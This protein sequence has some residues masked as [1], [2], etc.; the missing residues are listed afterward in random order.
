MC[1]SRA[2]RRLSPFALLGSVQQSCSTCGRLMSICGKFPTAKKICASNMMSY[3]RASLLV[4]TRSVCAE[5][6][7][8]RLDKDCANKARMKLLFPSPNRIHRQNSLFDFSTCARTHAQQHAARLA[9]ACGI[10]QTKTI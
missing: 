8:A 6:K 5:T 2:A 4:C 1:L 7:K 9:V 10:Q 3:L